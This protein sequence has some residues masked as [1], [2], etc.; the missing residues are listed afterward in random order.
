M[1]YRGKQHSV[2]LP[3]GGKWKWPAEIEGQYRSGMAVSRPS[4]VKLAERAIDKA[5]APKK[6]RSSGMKVGASVGVRNLSLTAAGLAFNGIDFA[7][8]LYRL[9]HHRVACSIASNARMFFD[10]WCHLGP[11]RP[12]TEAFSS[13]SERSLPSSSSISSASL[14]VTVT[15][16][17]AI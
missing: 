9:R 1:E 11:F 10:L 8:R 3:I 4:G 5:L 16:A 12:A 13:F 2:I 15:R 14:S 6:K 7:A 17:A